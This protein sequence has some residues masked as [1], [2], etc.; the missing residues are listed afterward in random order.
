MCTSITRIHPALFLTLYK[1][2][3]M[4]VWVILVKHKLFLSHLHIIDEAKWNQ[5]AE[6]L[7]QG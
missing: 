2:Y 3:L 7:V 5:V 1:N 4:L 6:E